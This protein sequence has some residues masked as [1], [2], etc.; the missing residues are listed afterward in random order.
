MVVEGKEL[1]LGVVN[2]RTPEVEDVDAV[3]AQVRGAL[4]HLPPERIF[5]NPDCGFGTF[6]GRPMNTPDLA[7]RKLTAVAQAAALLR[8]EY[9]A[10]RR[11]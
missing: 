2:P 1:G 7:A 9:G 6:S 10:E 5:L 8:K 4:C 11:E 3:V